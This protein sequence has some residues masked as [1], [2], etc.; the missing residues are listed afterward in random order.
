MIKRKKAM[1]RNQFLAKMHE[2]LTDTKTRLMQDIAAQLRT[3]RDTD[4]DECMDSCDLASEENDR[5]VSTMLSARERLKLGQIDEALRRTA[6]QTY[7]LCE[8]CGLDV[9]A[10][11]LQAMPFTRLCCDCQQEREHHAKTR[12]TYQKEDH[13]GYD[14]GSLHALEESNHGSPMSSGNESVLERLTGPGQRD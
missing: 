10:E 7:G 14:L 4:R 1:S 8:M 3:G 11:R 13:Q 2:Y 9:T 6:S 5:E 12:R